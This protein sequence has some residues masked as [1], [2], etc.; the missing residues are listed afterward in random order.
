[1]NGA[2]YK[3]TAEDGFEKLLEL[4][5]NFITKIKNNNNNIFC[6]TG[7]NGRIYKIIPKAKYSIEC[8][9]DEEQIMDFCIEKDKLCFFVTGDNGTIYKSKE[10][11]V[12]SS[13]YYSEIYDA[14]AFS[15]WGTLYLNATANLLIETRSGNTKKTD[16]FWSD[17]SKINN[18]QVIKSPNAR[19]LQFRV[20]WQ[21]K[22]ALLKG[23]KIIYQPNNHCPEVTE[24]KMDIP[25]DSTRKIYRD[26]PQKTIK[27][28]WKCKD[29]DKDKLRYE[30][31][32]K[33]LEVEHWYKIIEEKNYDKK[34]YKWDTQNI[35]DGFYII[36]FVATDDLEN[37]NS[38]QAIHKTRSILI[39]NHPPVI[40]FKK[41]QNQISGEVKDNF[42]IISQI[43]YRL[44][45]NKW[46]ILKPVDGIYDT[47]KEKFIFAIKFDEKSILEIKALDEAGNISHRFVK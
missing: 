42:S 4:K 22:G 25:D 30:L 1:M 28:K 36:K 38:K 8:D 19:Y 34:D 7:F 29:Q 21:D 20:N 11:K 45:N 39:D 10:S 18:E 13:Y 15:K 5:K 44:D 2:V 24:F 35:P 40:S 16:K 3:Y 14:N 37:F 27:F 33:N 17:W 32:Y 9:I 12:T 6:S 26:E 43:S 41:E 47:I 23:I 46:I 31:Y